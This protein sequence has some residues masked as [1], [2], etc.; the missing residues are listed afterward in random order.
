MKIDVH[1]ADPQQAGMFIVINVESLKGK[2]IISGKSRAYAE[3]V[4]NQLIAKDISVK[5]LFTLA[6]DVTAQN[7][8]LN[9]VHIKTEN[10][11]EVSP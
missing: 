5:D 8:W 2:D 10:D 7:V 9:I 3:R 11:N 1:G 6:K 4:V